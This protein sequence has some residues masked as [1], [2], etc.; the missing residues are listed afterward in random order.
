MHHDP[1]VYT[2]V[3]QAEQSIG[4]NTNI[5]V[6]HPPDGLLGAGAADRAAAAVP[7]DDVDVG[8]LCGAGSEPDTGLPA[9]HSSH[10]YRSSLKCTVRM[11]SYDFKK[12]DFFY[13]FQDFQEICKVLVLVAPCR[14]TRAWP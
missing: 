6:S 14:G 8:G 5:S 11:I 2:A 9:S 3:T 4:I 12:Y 13:S 10:Q 7:L 1:G